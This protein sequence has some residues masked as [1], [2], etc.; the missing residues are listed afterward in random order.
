M[1]KALQK[2][3]K[4]T[5]ILC[6]NQFLLLN[7]FSFLFLQTS[8]WGYLCDNW[9]PSFFTLLIFKW[10]TLS[11]WA[12]A[13]WSRQRAK[14]QV[15][16]NQ[17]SR[18]RW[19]QIE[20]R[21]ICYL[22]TRFLCLFTCLS[23]EFSVS[24]Y[25]CFILF[26]SFCYSHLLPTLLFL[27]KHMTCHVFT[28]KISNLNKNLSRNVPSVCLNQRYSHADWKSTDEWSLTCFKSILKISHS[29]YL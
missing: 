19:G 8:L 28:R 20:R 17:N 9:K 2:Q 5:F 22:S 24:F 11:S 10:H 6:I 3:Y 23:L 7:I 15:L 26:R 25:S 4:T 18:N 14:N 12:T 16:T 29:S 27:L 21:T 13:R 1:R